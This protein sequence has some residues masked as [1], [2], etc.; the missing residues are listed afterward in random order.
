MV[1]PAIP[2]EI[3]EACK[4][5][6]Q[7]PNSDLCIFDKAPRRPKLLFDTGTPLALGRRHGVTVDRRTPAFS[8]LFTLG[9]GYSF[10]CCR[11]LHLGDRSGLALVSL[12]TTQSETSNPYA[13][14]VE[15]TLARYFRQSRKYR[16]EASISSVTSS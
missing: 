13:T 11:R 7:G 2:G 16:V 10:F 9:H 3:V 12:S 5:P 1:H 6:A 4:R 15:P 14:R 8:L